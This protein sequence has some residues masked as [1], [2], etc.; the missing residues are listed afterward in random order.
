MWRAHAWPLWDV[1]VEWSRGAGSRLNSLRRCP[2]GLE[3]TPVG[4]EKDRVQ[5]IKVIIQKTK[6]MSSR[7][8]TS[9]Q[10]DGETVETLA[11]TLA[12]SCE[13][14]TYLKRP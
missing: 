4:D 1:I 6:I 7:Y 13:E 10:I 5:E 11:N 8:I 9:W 2:D 3:F 14:L 12:T